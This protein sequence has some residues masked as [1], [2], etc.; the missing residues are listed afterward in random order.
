M[1]KLVPVFSILLAVGLFFSIQSFIVKKN[2]VPSVATEVNAELPV[3]P[4]KKKSCTA[5]QK[6]ACKKSKTAETTN[7]V[8][9]AKD[10]QEYSSKK[11]CTPAQKAACKKG[12]T[13]IVVNQVAGAKDVAGQEL[14]TTKEAGK[15]SCTAAEKKACAAKKSAE[16]TASVDN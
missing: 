14:V 8:A 11:T 6:A 1:K 15:S 12:S 7:M 13:E 4:A 10:V 5:A 16:K 2:V 9:G 3:D